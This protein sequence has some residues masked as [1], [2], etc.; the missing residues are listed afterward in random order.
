MI[1]KKFILNVR[2]RIKGGYF[3]IAFFFVFIISVAAFF[4]YDSIFWEYSSTKAVETIIDGVEEKRVRHIK[5][6]ESVKAIYMT[7]CVAGTPSMRERLVDLADS[8]EINSIIINIKDETGR[9]SFNTDNP[10]LK[11]AA[12]GTCKVADM[13]EFIEYLHEKNIYTIGR[14]AVFQDPYLVKKNPEL[15][16]KE[17]G[18]EKVW[19]DR[20][21]LSWISVCSKESWDYTIEL[22]KESEKIGFDE[23]NFDYI[24][25]PSDGDMN[26]ISYPSCGAVTFSKQDRLEDFFFYLNKGLRDLGI[27]TSADLFGMVATN[28]DDLNIG[29]V[30][31]RAEP[32]FDFIAPMVYP[33]HYPAGFKNLSD[34]N[35]YPYEIIKYSM[36]EAARRLV[37]AS[38]TPLKLRPWLQDFDYPVT[39]TADMVRA[40]IKATYDAG[41]T[42][43][44]LWDPSNK[45]T[46]DALE[47]Q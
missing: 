25:F 19:R 15:A 7:A 37:A 11:D 1:N 32:Y 24:R 41:L 3:L 43:W 34:P 31:E 10:L 29:Q 44:M 30:L 36:D 13:A 9:I 46:R 40:Q 21:G 47:A 33:S 14:I 42:S 35:K 38:S 26:N 18:G 20:K 17:R 5:T 12:V 8:T 23:L 27:P 2:K 4:Y 6:P 28:K 22:A 16:V 39:Y 45:Y